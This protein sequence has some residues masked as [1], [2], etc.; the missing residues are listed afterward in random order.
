MASYRRDRINDAVAKE[1]NIAIREV[2][3][4]GVRDNFVT[5]TR[6]EVAPDLRNATVYYSC[7]AGDPREVR[8][9]LIRCTGLLRRHLAT[10]I[11]LRLTPTLSFVHDG[12]IEHGARIAELLH[13]I[14]PISD[15][16]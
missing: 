3:D 12:S 7:M 15:G 8:K 11:N 1:L 14:G 6:C 9:A 5:V 13:D 4:P 16:E 10:T 2:G